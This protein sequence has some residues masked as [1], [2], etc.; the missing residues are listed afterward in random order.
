MSEKE[1]PAT[2]RQRLDAILHTRDVSQVRDFLIAQGQWSAEAPADPELA[3]WLMIA[4]SQALSDL[5][6][7]AYAWLVHHG[8][9]SEAQALLRKRK[10]RMQ[11]SGSKR[12]KK[13][14]R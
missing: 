3:M 11:R 9:E 14:H 1:Q 10:S 7:Q 12:K 2:F 13:N 5:H 8:Y 6:E 4:G